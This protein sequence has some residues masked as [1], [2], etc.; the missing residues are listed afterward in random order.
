MITRGRYPGA[1][2]VHLHSKAQARLSA[3][4]SMDSD[5]LSFKFLVVLRR[6][7]ANTSALAEL[8][9]A[10]IDIEDCRHDVSRREACKQKQCALAAAPHSTR[11]EIS[12]VRFLPVLS[13]R[14]GLDELQPP[15]PPTLN[16]QHAHLAHSSPVQTLSRTTNSQ[17][18]GSTRLARPSRKCS[19]PALD[20]ALRGRTPPAHTN[21]VS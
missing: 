13:P 20:L 11:T 10:R 4:D 5:K 12:V 3:F 17:S 14:P 15:A 8:R 19:M 18:C 1:V 21:S 2:A 9:C 16:R 7:S 6:P